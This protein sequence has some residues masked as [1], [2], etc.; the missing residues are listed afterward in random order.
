ML[1]L[2][3]CGRSRTQSARC[4]ASAVA[5]SAPILSTLCG[6]TDNKNFNLEKSMGINE[7]HVLHCLITRPKLLLLLELMDR[8]PNA[9][10]KRSY[11]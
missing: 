2:N 8:A 9:I 4:I 10:Y 11:L 3:N 5:Q 6:P 7:R 1:R